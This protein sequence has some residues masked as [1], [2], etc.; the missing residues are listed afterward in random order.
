[1]FFQ[2]P[3]SYLA[4][5]LADFDASPDT[6]ERID[7]EWVPMD[8]DS[9]YSLSGLMIGTMSSEVVALWDEAEAAEMDV[10]YSEVVQYKVSRSS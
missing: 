7:G 3:P 6:L 5:V 8:P 9:F 2:P 10:P 1:M 4:V